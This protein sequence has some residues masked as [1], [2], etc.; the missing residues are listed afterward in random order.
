MTS[1]GVEDPAR[2]ARF[3]T[4]IRRLPLMIGKAGNTRLPGGPYTIT[5]FLAGGLVLFVGYQTMTIWGPLVGQFPL[6]RLFALLGFAA[7]AMWLSGQLPSTKR[8]LHNMVADLAGTAAAPAAGTVNGRPVRLRPPHR[9]YGTVRLATPSTPE[10]V[11]DAVAATDPPD[12]AAASAVLP[13]A[14]RFSSGL[15]RLLAQARV[16]ES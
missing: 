2:T 1:P 3:F 8:K 13:V 9:V 14:L 15:D 7:G 12:V 4:S 5:Q 10:P 6:V 11:V 16:K